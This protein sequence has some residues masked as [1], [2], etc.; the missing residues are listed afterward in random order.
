MAVTSFRLTRAQLHCGWSRDLDP[1]IAIPSGAELSIEVQ[2]ASGGQ[3]Q[4]ASSAAAIAGL[5][6]ARV[7]PATGPVC[8]EG[9]RPGDVLQID[10]LAIE[11]ASW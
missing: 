5:D 3:I 10:L 9:A 11:P 7:N 2:D 8:V 6:F 1:V 4:A